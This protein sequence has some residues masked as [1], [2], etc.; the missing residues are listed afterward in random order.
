MDP[1]MQLAIEE[2][3]Q[4]RAEGNYPYG[5][6]LASAAARSS[7]WGRNHMKIRIMIPPAI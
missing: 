5:S 7:A 4:V 2:Q 6:V 3:E 1:D